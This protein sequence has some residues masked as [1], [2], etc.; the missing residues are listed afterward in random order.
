M[1]KR[2]DRNCALRRLTTTSPKLRIVLNA[3]GGRR[4]F[5]R[6]AGSQIPGVSLKN[7]RH[8][9]GDPL[10]TLALRR[11]ASG[12][13]RSAFV[14]SCIPD[15]EGLLGAKSWLCRFAAYTICPCMDVRTSQPSH[16]PEPGAM[17]GEPPGEAP[18]SGEQ[19]VRVRQQRRKKSRMVSVPSA[20]AASAQESGGPNSISALLSADASRCPFRRRVDYRAT[21]RAKSW[22]SGERRPWPPELAHWQPARCRP[23]CAPLPRSQ[24]SIAMGGRAGEGN[25]APGSAPPCQDGAATAGSFRSG[26]ATH[27]ATTHATQV[28]PARGGGGARDADL[29][30]RAQ[31]RGAAAR[32]PAVSR[33]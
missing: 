16:S 17:E 12:L 26:W 18:D 5:T 21:S 32:R 20:G 7:S 25:R 3:A 33:C 11:R 2:A 10:W 6:V 4:E 24:V 22:R 23:S 14:A 1:E 30:H 15:S 9:V 27:A 19:P 31:A 29:P 8:G 13:E 28:P